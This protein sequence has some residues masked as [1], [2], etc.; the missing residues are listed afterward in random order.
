MQNP[1]SGTHGYPLSSS[2]VRLVKGTRLVLD[3]VVSGVVRAYLRDFGSAPSFLDLEGPVVSQALP[4]RF[5]AHRWRK[6]S[7]KR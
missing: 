3:F 2:L 7:V 5:P 6:I 1:E 4:G